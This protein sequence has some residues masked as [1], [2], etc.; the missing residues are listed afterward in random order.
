MRAS[1]GFTLLELLISMSLLSMVV[2]IGSSSFA[3]FSD[4]WDGQ[5][6]RFDDLV[7]ETRSILLVQ[8]VLDSLLPYV[9]YDD[10]GKPFIYFEGNRNGFVAVSSRSVFSDGN[11]SVA[12]LSAIQNTDLTFDIVYDEWPMDRSLLVSTDQTLDFSAPVILFESVADPKFQ[13]F[14]WSNVE[15]R[16]LDDGLEASP[17]WSGTYNGLDAWFAPLNVRLSFFT[18]AGRYQLESSLAHAKSGLLSRY[19]ER[20]YRLNPKGVRQNDRESID[21]ETTYDDCD[22]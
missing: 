11:F 18:E 12:R 5:L 17:E 10:R 19:S 15:Q 9:A 3:L 13:Y 14:G 4:R 22:C 8:D 16:T 21:E 20:S 6:G 1:R 2:L 7:Q